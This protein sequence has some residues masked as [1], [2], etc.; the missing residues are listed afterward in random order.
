MQERKMKKLMA[1]ILGLLLLSTVATANV[2]EEESDK[3]EN[4]LATRSSQARETDPSP[5]E[6]EEKE[7]ISQKRSV[8]RG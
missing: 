8:K 4:C 1:L 2:N 7:E 5:K 3:P 6:D